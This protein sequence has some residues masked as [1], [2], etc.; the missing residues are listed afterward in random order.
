MKSEANVGNQHTTGAEGKWMPRTVAQ[1]VAVAFAGL[2]A[3]LT[4]GAAE[5]LASRAPIA[6]ERSSPLSSDPQACAR[7]YYER[8]R[9]DV[10]PLTEDIW[11]TA[12]RMRK[13]DPTLPGHWLF[14]DGS[15]ILARTARQRRL[16]RS[17]QF[18]ERE[19]RICVHSVLARGG[20]I[21]C[22][23]WQDV[24]ADYEPPA[25]KAPSVQATR[26]DISDG[27]RQLAAGVTRRVS[28]RGGIVELAAGTAFYHLIK[29]T[30]DEIHG[31]A[32]QD[33]KAGLCT[34][35]LEM[36]AFYRKRLASLERKED[37]AVRLAANAR[38]AAGQTFQAAASVFELK[39]ITGEGE[40]GRPL[41]LKDLFE[42][43]LS[44]KER[45][46]LEPYDP[47]LELLEKARN[48]LSD[49]RF[50]TLGKARGGA[51]RKVLRTA[52]IALY[53]E[54][55]ADRIG[56]LNAAFA[57]SFETI[58]DAHKAACVCGH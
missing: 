13:A 37:D 41:G 38:Q 26:P 52:E 46:S 36:I 8:L 6:E 24:P 48:Y 30:A 7:A 34:G 57:T 12:V 27:E 47:D 49:E 20:R 55:N 43:V 3:D 19:S 50:E 28:S 18:L 5:L 4:P 31:Y 56:Q 22:L 54:I 21:R 1:I 53:A 44:A 9:R 39:A 58:L 11:P 32:G 29:R 23:K 40:S 2:L 17:T 33:F 15:G 42:E 14:W 16:L 35:V 25:P 45:A 51:L 10:Q